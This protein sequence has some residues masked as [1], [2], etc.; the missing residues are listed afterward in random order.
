M[1]GARLRVGTVQFLDVGVG[2]CSVFSVSI[3]GMGMGIDR[4]G[5]RRHR[6]RD[7]CRSWSLGQGC[8]ERRPWEGIGYL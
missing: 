5:R 4:H 1:P 7:L 2:I 3:V 8:D 6:L